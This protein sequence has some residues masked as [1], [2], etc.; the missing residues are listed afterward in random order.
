MFDHPQCFQIFVHYYGDKAKRNLD[1]TA[2]T[3]QSTA[4]GLIIDICNKIATF[5][6]PPADLNIKDDWDKSPMEWALE[7]MYNGC[8]LGWGAVDIFWDENIADNWFF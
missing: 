6:V 1:E 8:G 2:R 3:V 5:A 4:P 7:T